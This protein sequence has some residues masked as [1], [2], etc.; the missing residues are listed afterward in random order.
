MTLVNM[1]KEFGSVRI[2]IKCVSIR[3]VNESAEAIGF[4]TNFYQALKYALNN[5][6]G[7]AGTW[8]QTIYYTNEDNGYYFYL[9]SDV[10]AE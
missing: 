6:S 4:D 8:H 10:V 7:D 5:F 1:F 2:N 9:A 3:D